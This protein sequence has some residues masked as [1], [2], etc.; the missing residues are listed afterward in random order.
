M[1]QQRMTHGEEEDRFAARFAPSCAKP[2]AKLAEV[3]NEQCE[4]PVRRQAKVCPLYRYFAGRCASK[5]PNTVG[6]DTQLDCYR[7]AVNGVQST[8]RPYSE[9]NASV[10]IANEHC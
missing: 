6:C 8:G 2:M 3:V 1:Q 4:S 5:T 9:D 10:P 7:A